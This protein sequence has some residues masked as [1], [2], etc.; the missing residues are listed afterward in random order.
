VTRK[1]GRPTKGEDGLK[2]LIFAR[3]TVALHAEFMAFIERE[4]ARRG[5]PTLSCSD[6]VRE[7]VTE[8]IRAEDRPMADVRSKFVYDVSLTKEEMRLIGLGLIGKLGVPNNESPSVRTRAADDVRAAAELNL[9]LL[10]GMSDMHEQQAK[11]IDHAQAL[12][13]EYLKTLP[14]PE[15]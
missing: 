12:G 3:V 11:V 8:A 5:L 14:Y 9:K 15:E 1:R 6:I 2:A 7:M 13:V 4:R 10:K